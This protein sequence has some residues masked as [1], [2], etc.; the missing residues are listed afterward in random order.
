MIET[1]NSEVV[2]VEKIEVQ[3]EVKVVLPKIDKL[4]RAYATGKRKKSPP[5]PYCPK[6]P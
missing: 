4:G 1:E 5:C 2:S 6:S 3:E